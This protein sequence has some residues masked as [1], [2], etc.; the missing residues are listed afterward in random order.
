LHWS[1]QQLDGLIDVLVD[2]VLRELEA[3]NL[4]ASLA[5]AKNPNPDAINDP[6]GEAS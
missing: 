5:P 2:A 3:E 1:P 6:N 4:V